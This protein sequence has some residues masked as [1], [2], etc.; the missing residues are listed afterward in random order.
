MAIKKEFK[1]INWFKYENERAVLLS[2]TGFD[3]AVTRTYE[4][5]EEGELEENHIYEVCKI[6]IVQNYKCDDKA[7]YSFILQDT[8]YFD[9]LIKPDDPWELTNESFSHQSE[10]F[11]KL[12]E[13]NIE[14]ED[15]IRNKV[16]DKTR[17]VSNDWEVHKLGANN[18]PQLITKK[19]YDKKWK[20][21]EII[22]NCVLEEGIGIYPTIY[23]GLV[24][25]YQHYEI[26]YLIYC[27]PKPG[28]EGVPEEDLLSFPEYYSNRQK[29][30]YD[31]TFFQTVTNT[32]NGRIVKCLTS[33]SPDVDNFIRVNKKP[34]PKP[35]PKTKKSNKIDFDDYV[36]L[37]LLLKKDE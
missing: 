13:E 27:E 15:K 36:D 28:R 6:T 4:P 10:Y 20:P 9:T 34:E 3:I 14:L 22:Y 19:I 30:Y 29:D 24:F 2:K 23:I 11:K 21:F 7:D 37:G 8:N 18:Q 35:E 33:M 32:T 16:S 26:K 5:C 12:Y 31:I 17:Y 25:I 1:V